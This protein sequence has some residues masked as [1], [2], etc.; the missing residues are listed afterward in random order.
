MTYTHSPPEKDEFEITLLGPGY[1][2][3]VL[4]HVGD[5]AWIVVDS[6]VSRDNDP[7]ALQYLEDLGLDPANV[8]DL[9][10]ATHW[11][12]DH[13]RG[14]ARLVEVCKRAA[15]CC[16]GVLGKKEFLAT[17]DALER[18]HLSVTGSGV[19]EIH[20]VFSQLTK[21]KSKPILAL[22]DRRLLSD[23]TCEIW[24]L[25]PND[26][27]FMDF[28]KSIGRAVHGENQGT[29]RTLSLS[30]NRVAVVLWIH[31]DDVVILLGSD[32]EKHRWADILHS[33]GRP[34][35]KAAVF[36]VPH[37]GAESANEPRVWQQLLVPNPHAVLT[38][39]TLGKRRLPSEGDVRRILSHTSNAY[40]T[41]AHASVL[42]A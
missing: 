3:C 12:D 1:G 28:L 35:S 18:R 15:F 4:L 13:I 11:H 2:E 8:V 22:A 39:W 21:A 20:D 41:S 38:P 33:P 34:N 26:K 27:D 24:T 31:V 36:K 29:G 19:R 6:C 42:C 25:S 10:V 17:V 37:H 9:I 5:G 23:G 32:L 40:T 30:P 14:M 7:V 16:A